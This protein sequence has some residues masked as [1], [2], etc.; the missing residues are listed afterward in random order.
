MKYTAA[1][2][3]K[4]C[5]II[6]T[7]LLVWEV[8]VGERNADFSYHNPKPGNHAVLDII[9]NH[10]WK[11]KTSTVPQDESI[12]YYY[13]QIVES[14]TA[15][16]KAPKFTGSTTLSWDEASQTYKTT[17]T[18]SNKV[19]SSIDSNG[20]KVNDKALKS[21]MTIGEQNLISRKAAIKSRFQPKRVRQK[22]GA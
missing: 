13:N 3:K 6:A 22:N 19:L 10:P 4:T 7:Q 14:V 17:L 15:R 12:M 21:E 2:R 1:N 16:S 18:D 11:D 20:I 8:V 9:Q 5:K